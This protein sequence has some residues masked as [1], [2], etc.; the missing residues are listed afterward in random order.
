MAAEAE[1]WLTSY[2]RP[3]SVCVLPSAELQRKLD[4][5]TASAE[6]RWVKTVRGA[7]MLSEAELSAIEFDPSEEDLLEARRML[8]SAAE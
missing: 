7:R 6:A 1:A 8:E 4:Q 2:P 5:S 3:R